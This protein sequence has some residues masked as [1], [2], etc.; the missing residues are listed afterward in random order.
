[1]F[2]RKDFNEK[3]ALLGLLSRF[4][5]KEVLEILKTVLKK[6]HFLSKAG[7][8]KTSLSAVSALMVNPSPE[9]LEILKVGLW[10]TH[11]KVRKAA[12]KALAEVKI[13]RMREDS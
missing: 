13:G 5:S 12:R 4:Q 2:H 1:V 10:S 3:S 6:S 8:V 11:H 7:T 9:S